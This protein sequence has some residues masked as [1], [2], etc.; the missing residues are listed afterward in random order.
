[1]T[2]A[3]HDHTFETFNSHIQVHGG[4]DVLTQLADHLLQ[5]LV[6]KN[7]GHTFDMFATELPVLLATK[8][9]ANV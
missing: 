4:T 1:M 2:A 6:T 5:M 3:N 9:V 8:I 7:I